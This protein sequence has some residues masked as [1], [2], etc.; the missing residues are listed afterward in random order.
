MANWTFRAGVN[1]YSSSRRVRKLQLT[2][3]T[4]DQIP[5]NIC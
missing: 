2:I 1:R 5:E 3:L 4:G